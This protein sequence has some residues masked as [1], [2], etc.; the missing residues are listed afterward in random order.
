M[1]TEAKRNYR[2]ETHGPGGKTMRENMPAVED[3]LAGLLD[4]WQAVL[5]ADIA[6]LDWY[7]GEEEEFSP[8]DYFEGSLDVQVSDNR[9]YLLLGTGGPHIE[10]DIL[11]RGGNAYEIIMRR[12]WWGEGDRAW[13]RSGDACDIADAMFG[14]LR[15]CG[16]GTNE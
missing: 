1:T 14:Y 2:I 3:A 15:G 7:E 5:D 16:F 6:K 4:D 12:A 11:C 13:T 8:L 9:C 10:V